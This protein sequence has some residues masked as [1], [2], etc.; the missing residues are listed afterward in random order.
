MAY[1]QTDLNNIRRLIA[2]GAGKVM[3][4]GK[5]VEYRSLDELQ[6]IEA[7]IAAEV[8]GSN[9]SGR[10]IVVHSQKGW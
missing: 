8:N 5:T 7:R 9:R 1:T 2:A 4:A 6:R 10:N 3:I